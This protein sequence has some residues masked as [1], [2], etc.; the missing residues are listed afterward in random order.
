[1]KLITEQKKEK[2]ERVF[3]FYLKKEANFADE[4]VLFHPFI[5]TQL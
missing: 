4:I 1:M 5:P 3:F 2:K